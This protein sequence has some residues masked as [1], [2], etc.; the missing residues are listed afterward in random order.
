MIELFIEGKQLDVSDDLSHLMTFALDDIKDFASRNSSFS[1]TIILPGTAKNNYLFGNIYNVTISNNYTSS[2]ANVATNFNA[3]I[4]AKCLIFQNRLQVFKGTLR[5]LEIVISDGNIEYEVSVVGELGGLVSALGSKKLEDLDF[6][7]YDHVWNVGNIT[8]SWDNV[9]GGTYYYPLIDYGLVSTNKVDYDVTALRPALYVKE[10]IDKIFSGAGFTYQ[11]DLLNTQRFKNLIIP[12]NQKVLSIKETNTLDVEQGQLLT[13][14]IAYGTIN[15]LG[16][17]THNIDNDIWTYTG[18]DTFVGLFTLFVNFNISGYGGYADMVFYLYKNGAQVASAGPYQYNEGN[19]AIIKDFSVGVANGD[20]FEVRFLINDFGETYSLAFTD[21]SFTIISSAP[22]ATAVN[23]GDT[24]KINDT[25]PRNILQKDFLSSI[26]KLFNLYLYDDQ[27]T[28]KMMYMKPYPDFYN[29]TGFTDWTYKVDRGR[30]LRLKPMSELNSRFYDF[31]FKDDS[32]YYNDL[33]KK[34]YN[35]TFG[36]YLYDSA[37]EFVNDKTEIPLIFSPTPLVGYVGVDKIVPAIYKKTGTTE[38]QMQSNIRI[39]QAKK[40]IGVTAWDVLDGASVLLSNITA[41]GYAG[42]YDDPD[43]P[44]NDIHFGVP[45]ELY[46]TLV[47]GAVNVTQFNVYWS[48]YMAEITDKDSKLLSCYLKLT[49]VDILN[50]DFS[51]FIYIDGSYWR[52]NKIEDWNAA[53]PDVCRA[54]FLKVINLYY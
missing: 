34:T 43:A 3:A 21:S 20:Y 15:Q 36:A 14:T 32:D 52:L 40:V 5:L 51:K 50:L 53:Q 23:Y 2:S 11:S 7:L 31:T 28:S 8:G 45:K 39:L 1:K 41:Y 29:V 9:T 37:F 42:N 48:A 19:V 10:Y 12:N 38:E 30:E 22:V 26:V 13:N 33:Y 47:S 24:I 17:F 27:Y 46:F 54:E 16:S 25:I 4:S 35:E 44:A 6:S 18:A 49:P